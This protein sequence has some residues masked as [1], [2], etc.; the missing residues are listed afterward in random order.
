MIQ[1]QESLAV[2]E[3]VELVRRYQMGWHVRSE[4]AVVRG[5][6]V[7]IGFVVELTATHDV[8]AHSPSPGCDECVPVRRALARV[9]RAVLPRGEHTSWYDVSVAEGQ[10][11][12][13]PGRRS[14]PLLTATISVLHTG[15]VNAPPDDCER[16]CLEEI[17]GNLVALGA[18]ERGA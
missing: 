15:D 2:P 9:A 6:L 17:R 1:T 12:Y 8:P 11:Q 16:A 10:L 3:L 5:A 13:D 7:P 18:R 4:Q 14:R